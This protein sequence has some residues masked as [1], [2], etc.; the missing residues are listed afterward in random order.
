MVHKRLGLQTVRALGP[1]SVVWDGAIPGFGARRQNSD[2]IVYFLKYRTAEGRQRWFTIGRHGA[3]WTPDTARAEALRLLGEIVAK[4]DPAAVKQNSRNAPTVASLCDLYLEDAATGRL[5]TRRRTSKTAATLQT[6]RSRIGCH[7]KPLLG[8][9]AV[10]AVTRE[11]IESFL[12]AI[13]AGKTSARGGRGAASRTVGLLGA[14]FAYAV[15]HRL[16]PDNPVH[17]VVRPADGRRDRRLSEAEYAALGAALRAAETADLWPPAIAAVRFLALTG[18]RSGEAL[19]LRWSQVDLPRRTAILSETKTGRSM[20]P[21][22]LAA[23][24]V[25]RTLAVLG[26]DLVFA[27]ARGDGL[28]K[29][30]A[31]WRRIAALAQLPHD[32]TP[33]VLR[34]SFAS[35]AAD[36]G[37]AELTIAALIGHKGH[38]VTS[39]YV[40]SADAVLLAAA[41]AVAGR[42]AELM[43]GS[44]P[45]RPD[46]G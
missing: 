43:T 9:R 17:G 10:G 13:A 41:D 32:V 14:I 22:G 1:D 2:A 45:P 19:A 5:M 44:L 12:H 15:K 30:A 29:L 46:A 20:R 31:P 40:H 11:D 8:T 26:S 3:P 4:T 25:L 42:T 37:F 24:E 23:C 34:H 35:L 36:L 18:W 7:I 39:R 16:R 33:H 38:S 6:D 28:L 21:L 27:S